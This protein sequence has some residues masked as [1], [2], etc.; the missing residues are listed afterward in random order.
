MGSATDKLRAE[1]LFHKLTGGV[2]SRKHDPDGLPDANGFRGESDE[3]LRARRKAE[4][5][6]LGD[7]GLDRINK[8][9]ER[10]MKSESESIHKSRSIRLRADVEEARAEAAK[11]RDIADLQACLADRDFPGF[12]PDDPE[13]YAFPWEKADG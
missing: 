3:A 2:F 1:V 10:M 6:H 7:D 13:S 11:W 12:K 5:E 8:E 9:V 4:Y